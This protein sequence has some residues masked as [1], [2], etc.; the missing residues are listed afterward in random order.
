MRKLNALLISSVLALSTLVPGSFAVFFDNDDR[1]TVT[2]N[3]TDAN[4]NPAVGNWYFYAGRNDKGLLYRNG[5]MGEKFQAPTGYYH[6]VFF[7]KYP[8][9]SVK[10]YSENTQELTKGGSVT[11][12]LVYFT[13]LDNI[14]GT[15]PFANI[16]TGEDV[17]VVLPEVKEPVK[18]VEV[19]KK[20][21]EPAKSTVEPL[22]VDLEKLTEEELDALFND[23]D[24]SGIEESA[25]FNEP[26]LEGLL[27]PRSL[28]KTNLPANVTATVVKKEPV[29]PLEL[30]VTGPAGLLALFMTSGLSAA[31]YARRRRK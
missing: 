9:P 20:P 19:K 2:I 26:I 10:L 23:I 7:T 6:L 30:A 5:T 18:P 4:G 16:G 15:Y 22:E 31:L 1:G 29:L 12:N 25:F 17:E 3:V 11:F 14:P 8:Y 24:E 28:P 27:D 13:R 21:T